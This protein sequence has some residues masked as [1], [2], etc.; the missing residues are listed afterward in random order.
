MKRSKKKNVF[1]FFVG[2]LELL[3]MHSNVI[4]FYEVFVIIFSIEQFVKCSKNLLLIEFLEERCIIYVCA[5]ACRCGLHPVEFKIN[6]WMK[7]EKVFQFWMNKKKKDLHP[8]EDYIFKF[9]LQFPAKNVRYV[10]GPS[11]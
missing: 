3:L 4:C 11:P 7:K 6:I 5:S 8:V 10:G 9:R 1:I 2:K